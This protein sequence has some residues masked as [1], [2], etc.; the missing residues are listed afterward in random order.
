M[1]SATILASQVSAQTPA[2]VKI[3]PN[4]KSEDTR[5]KSNASISIGM[6][7]FNDMT[8][9]DFVGPHEVFARLP[10][11]KVY[12][13]AKS[14]D[15]ITTDAGVRV[16]PD[17]SLEQAPE[18]DLLFVGGGAGSTTLMED[19]KVLTFL[20]ERAPRAQWITS[21]CTGALVLGA[22]GLLQGYKAATHWRYMDILPILGAEPINE[23][24][25]IDRNRITGGGVTAG[26]DF[27]LTI[28]AE[29]FGSDLAQMLQLGQEYNPQPPFNAGSPETA[30]VEVVKRF[31]A[32][33][34]DLHQARTEAAKRAKKNWT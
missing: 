34:T 6:I 19:E 22:A 8:N 10:T 5:N 26:I 13:L 11:A 9:I 12:T 20:S 27:G 30:P 23:R 29:F 4:D 21:V 7:I 32:I 3:T 2:P 28:A 16:L 31:K 18:L 24:V 33:T 14:M 15:P 17:M 1:A 25:V